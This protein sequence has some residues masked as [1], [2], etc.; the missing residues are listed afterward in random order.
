MRKYTF[1]I[2]IL[3]IITFI[4]SNF[5]YSETIKVKEI[6]KIL[7]EYIQLQG[8]GLVV[9]LKG[10]G[11]TLKNISTANSISSYLKSLGIEISPTNF[12]ARNT[13]SVIVSAK[14]HSS[15]QKGVSFD[16]YVSSIFDSRSLEGGFLL[17][18]PLKDSEGNI[19]AFAQGNVITPKGGIKT[20][21][22]VPDGGILVSNLY[23]NSIETGKIRLFFEGS[24][25]TTISLFLNKVKEI[26]GEID[27]KLITSEI[28]EITL[29]NEFSKNPLEFISKIMEIELDMIEESYVVI[30]QKSLTVVITGNVRLYPSSISYKGMKITFSDINTLIESGEIYQIP[31]TNLKDFVDGLIKIGIK[32]EDLI[33]ILLLMKEAKSIKSKFIVK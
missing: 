23:M 27:I 15:S 32:T 24:S 20:T 17:K 18:T 3:I 5:S 7:D 22:L 4:K 1:L 26:F 16:V 21:G 8:Y 28:L 30:D 29:P 9:G 6:A 14:I 12:Q 11:D 31:S 2:Y 25:A 33:Q 13:A 10:T 19:L